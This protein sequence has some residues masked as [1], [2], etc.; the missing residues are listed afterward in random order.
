MST[1][2]IEATA[3]SFKVTIYVGLLP[4]L[5]ASKW[6]CTWQPF[7]LEQT[8][9]SITVG[10]RLR[11]SFV[12]LSLTFDLSLSF[13]PSEGGIIYTQRSCP[14]IG[15]VHETDDDHHTNTAELRRLELIER[16]Q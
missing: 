12:L 2:S 13:V 3:E 1:Q 4:L 5:I 6:L 7:C 14:L 8:C 16:L 15:I 11:G 10:P 9:C